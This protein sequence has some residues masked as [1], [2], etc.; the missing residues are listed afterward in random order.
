MVLPDL[1]LKYARIASSNQSVPVALLPSRDVVGASSRTIRIH[2]EAVGDNRAR[3]VE[4]YRSSDTFRLLFSQARAFDRVR[5][6]RTFCLELLKFPLRFG[7]HALISRIHFPRRDCRQALG[8]YRNGRE[9]ICGKHPTRD[10]LSQK[11]A[12]NLISHRGIP[13]IFRCKAPE[14]P[15]PLHTARPG[16]WDPNL[17]FARPIAASGKFH[18]SEWPSIPRLE[19][20]SP[21]S[22]RKKLAGDRGEGRLHVI[23]RGL[24][25][26]P[27][28][29]RLAGSVHA[30]SAR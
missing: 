3:Q 27:S 10:H 13:H 6:Q 9:S 17:S 28:H 2:L 24:T 1:Q 11:K 21:A 12:S 25:A 22:S 14:N 15:C 30:H 20:P 7:V 19:C 5:H 23:D 16:S 8:R 29:G 18:P 26:F 4:V